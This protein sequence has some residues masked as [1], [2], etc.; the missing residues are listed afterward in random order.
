MTKVKIAAGYV[1]CSTDMQ[2]DSVA[3]QK[4]SILLWAEKEGYTIIDW[5]EDEGKSGT[6][7][8]KRPAFMRM[9][10]CVQKK[11]N[12]DYVLVYDESRWGRAGD[13]R[14]SNYWKMHLKRYGVMVRVINSQSKNENDIGSYV[15]EVVESAEAS[16]Y[17]KKLSRATLRGCKSNA[18]NG[19]SNGGTAPYGYNRVAVSKVTNLKR[20]LHSGEQAHSGE[21]KVIWDL[22]DEREVETVK[23]IFD[24]KVNGFGYRKI[25]ELLNKENIP[26]ARRGRWRGLDQKWS[27]TTVISIITNP[28]YC[29]DRVYNRFALSKK[30][31]GEE[32]ILGQR[33]ESR[34][35]AEDNWVIKK[36]AH[37]A[38][39]SRE[40]FD[41]VNYRT[42]GKK[43]RNNHFLY[44][45]YLLTGLVKCSKC[46]FPLQGHSY[47]KDNLS[48]YTDSGYRNKGICRHYVVPKDVLE[49][50]VTDIVKVIS[51]GGSVVKGFEERVKQYLNNKKNSNSSMD[52][53]TRRRRENEKAISN[54][55]SLAEAGSGLV[56]IRDRI[57]KLEK[58]RNVINEE[59][60]KQK[61]ISRKEVEIKDASEVAKSYWRQFPEVYENVSIEEKKEMLRRVIVG[62]EYNP[63]KR[64]ATC[65]ITKIPMINPALSAVFPPEFVTEIC[66]GGG[67]RTH[68]LRIMIP[69]L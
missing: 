28:S 66:S 33:K 42:P 62:I 67:I 26:T 34:I 24:L 12:F 48:Y 53:L 7:F 10:E 41:A 54:L 51:A 21:E 63:D 45:P 56:E 49:K 16:E 27:I 55:L 31:N 35:A 38:I 15:V 37:P 8:E 17:S 3:Q 36:G 40:L 47:R 5:F 4:K 65:V 59:E 23:R 68:D 39:V 50:R 57:K 19:Y 60:R 9:V 32:N 46:G 6:S 29:G 18:E 14:E 30:R 64:E 2:D 61:A 58:E 22:G 20:V 52:S 13:P 69:T 11:P 25:A 1:R 44:S 43:K